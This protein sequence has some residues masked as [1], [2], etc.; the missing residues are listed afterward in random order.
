MERVIL[1]DTGCCLGENL[2]NVVQLKRKFKFENYEGVYPETQDIN[3][4]KF[5]RLLD[6]GLEL[7]DTSVSEDEVIDLVKKLKDSGVK[8]ILAIIPSEQ[9]RFMDNITYN[10]ILR[11][12][13]DIL[14]GITINI[15]ECP[16]DGMGM[17]MVVKEASKILDDAK[18]VD[19]VALHLVKT[20]NEYSIIYYGRHIHFPL[21][22]L[23]KM[24]YKRIRDNKYYPIYLEK[25]DKIKVIDYATWDK[26]AIER[27]KKYLTS[28]YRGSE[29]LVGSTYSR[30]LANLFMSEFSNL[31]RMD[32]FHI[33]K[34]TGLNL[35]EEMIA[36]GYRT[37]KRK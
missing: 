35:G 3:D 7:E 30:N 33:N 4:S 16:F 2:P 34:L 25:S 19:D 11:E 13:N 10:G 12:L 29:L 36:I 17:G 5:Y 37:E 20:M 1:T 22:G 32:Q 28:K 14:K 6:I 26:G 23:E 18:F 9:V 8:E 31:Y 27:I 24:K 21:K 15:V